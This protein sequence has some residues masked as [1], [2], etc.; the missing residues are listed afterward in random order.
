VLATLIKKIEFL[1]TWKIRI[2]GRAVLAGS[3]SMRVLPFL[4]GWI[5]TRRWIRHLPL[6]TTEYNNL[7]CAS[8]GVGCAVLP[9]VRTIRFQ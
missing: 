4:S 2:C 9:R 7:L 3:F 6:F 5:C 8:G 1:P